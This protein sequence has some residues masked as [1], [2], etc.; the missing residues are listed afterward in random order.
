[1]SKPNETEQHTEPVQT[2]VSPLVKKKLERAA[3]A[4][5]RSV[6][7]YVRRILEHYVKGIK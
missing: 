1:M 6:A 5:S 7:A 3:A 2:Y 4:D